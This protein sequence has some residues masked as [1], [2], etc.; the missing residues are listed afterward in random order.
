VAA[1]LGCIVL[2]LLLGIGVYAGFAPQLRLDVVVSRHLYAGD[3][4]SAALDA[5]LQVVTAP[6]LTVVRLVVAVPVLVLLARRRA[7]RTAAWVLVAVA[8][9]GPLTTLCKDVV[10]RLRPQ[11]ANGGAHLQSLSFPS[12]HSS[13]I[14][15]AVTVG[16]VLGWPLLSAHARRVWL[17]IGVAIVVVV[18]FSRMW[19][20]VHYLSDVVGGWSLGIAWALL[21]ALI[22][23]ALPGGRAALRP[24]Q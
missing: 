11:F 10:G 7:W 13:G 21:T 22:L 1:V 14:A 12:G 15:T 9:I 23:G 18:G 24:R 5:L 8:L 4:R 17:A 2:V 3:D 20:G 6:G 19:L 16:L